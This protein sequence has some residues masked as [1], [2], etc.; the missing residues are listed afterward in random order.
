MSKDNSIKIIASN[1]KA[2]FLYKLFD[3]YEA[4]IS[5]FGSEVKAIRESK[6]NIKESYI[7]AINNE[8]FLRGMYVGEYSHSGYEKHNPTRDRKLLLHK[9]EINNIIKSMKDVGKT[10]IPTTLYFK[11]SNI[12]IKFNIAK[13]KKLWDKRISKKNK[14]IEREI[15]RELKK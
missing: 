7:T 13:G 12:K 1:R 14:D 9:K 2:S 3:E 11:D 15:A 6:V 10:V 8:L 5:L 4:G